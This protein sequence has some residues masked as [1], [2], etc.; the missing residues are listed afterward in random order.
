MLYINPTLTLPNITKLVSN[1]LHKIFLN[2]FIFC[3]YPPI[4]FSKSI[5]KPKY[6]NQV[7]ICFLK[8]YVDINYI[9]NSLDVLKVTFN[10]YEWLEKIVQT[11]KPLCKAQ[12]F[13]YNYYIIL[14]LFLLDYKSKNLDCLPH[15]K[16]VRHQRCHFFQ[17]KLFDNKS[18]FRNF[19]NNKHILCIQH[20]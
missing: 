20:H 2:R 8:C 3:H 12:G 1:T 13:Y 7:F 11:T 4:L 14:L 19:Q 18:L 10:N 17:H 16:H 9:N 15:L 5:R 6:K